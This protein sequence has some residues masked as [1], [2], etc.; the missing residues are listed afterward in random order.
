MR[1]TLLRTVLAAAA[2][3]ACAA[4]VA[5][6]SGD[7]SEIKETV[8]GV[9]DAIAAKDAAKVCDSLSEEGKRQVTRGSAASRGGR[10]SCEAVFGFGLSVAGDALAKS[11]DTEVTDVKVNGDR[12]T[13]TVKLDDSSGDI[14]L[15]KEGGEW[16]IRDLDTSTAG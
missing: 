16:K 9:Y 8:N 7:E 14:G 13:A 3:A 10:Q 15:V 6:G 4:L 2:P 11:K 12:A 1:P 5:C